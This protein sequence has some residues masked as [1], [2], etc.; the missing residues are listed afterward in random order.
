MTTYGTIPTSQPTNASSPLD[1]ISRAKGMG[2]LALDT[3]RPWRELTDIHSFSLPPRSFHPLLARIKSNISYF[4]MNYAV[5]VLVIVFLSLLWHPISLIVFLVCMIAWLFFYFL[6][7]EPLVLFGRT[8]AEGVM[9]AALSVVTL[10]LLLLT[11]ATVNIL[12]SLGVGI[13]VVLV[14]AAVR[15]DEEGYTDLENYA[16]VGER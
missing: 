14:H 4:S 15:K 10:A 11:Q 12:V 8:I 9:L 16:A 6:R 1:Y 13:L 3:R 2:R 5:V 7:D